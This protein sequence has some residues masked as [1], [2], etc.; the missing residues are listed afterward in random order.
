MI[1]SMY[2][3]DFDSKKLDFITLNKELFKFVYT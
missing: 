1:V 3:F 2:V